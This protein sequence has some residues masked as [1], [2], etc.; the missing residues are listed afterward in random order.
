MRID[1]VGCRCWD[2]AAVNQRQDVLR[3]LFGY[4]FVPEEETYRKRACGEAKLVD[5]QTNPMP[6]KLR[7]ETCLELSS[8]LEAEMH[9]YAKVLGKPLVIGNVSS[10]RSFNVKVGLIRS[11]EK[12]F[13]TSK[14]SKVARCVLIYWH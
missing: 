10:S 4:G 13:S 6:S 5:R 11:L 3:T 12:G 7:W 1:V 9:H 14:A 2:G 8:D